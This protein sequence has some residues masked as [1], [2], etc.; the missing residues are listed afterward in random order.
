MNLSCSRSELREALR[1]VAG[2]VDPK[3][4]KPILKDI[5]LSA[6]EEGLEIS[7]TDLEVGIKYLVRDVEVKQTGG[8]VIPADPINGIVSESRTDRLNLETQDTKLVL[9][10]G[11]NRFNIMG[12]SEEEFPDI[13]DFP[14]DNALEVEGAIVREMIEKTIFAVAVEKQRYALNGVLFVVK[15]K[16]NRMEMVATDGRRLA[17]IRRKAN[18][19]SPVSASAIIPVKALQ[20]V[21][22]MVGV[23]EIVKINIQERQVLIRGENGVL[24]AQ[25]VEGRFP[26]YKEVIPDDCDKKLEV[27]SA[28][29]GNA[30]R[31]AAVLSMRDSRA[32]SMK[33]SEKTQ[34]LES[35]NPEA[36]DA[37]VEF[38]GKFE[39]DPVEIRFNPDF[40]LD[41][42]KVID[43]TIRFEM[44]DRTRAAVMRAGSDYLYLVM[45]ITQE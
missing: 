11:G 9:T 24:A 3:N 43:E 29:L 44:K 36:G 35:S 2:V 26:P 6:T 1:L 13:P 15:E 31:Q 39:G 27:E 17:M 21:Q 42:V 33:L 38:N 41:G 23:E 10:T 14:E 34:I 5:R 28:E 20:Q 37:H 22:K 30:V 18:V 4:I 40:L 19:A 7:A 25:L 45:P 12:V 16:S 32:V 8:I